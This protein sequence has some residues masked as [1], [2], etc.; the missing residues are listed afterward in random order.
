MPANDI[1]RVTVQE[2]KLNRKL[3]YD[4][5]LARAKYGKYGNAVVNFVVTKKPTEA[6]IKKFIKIRQ[7]LA[8]NK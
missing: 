8:K 7:N 6:Q 3:E 2:W 5:K 1:K 4:T